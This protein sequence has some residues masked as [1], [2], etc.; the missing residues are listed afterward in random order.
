[1]ASVVAEASRS[2]RASII[3]SAAARHQ[4]GDRHVEVE[5][6]LL[7]DQLIDARGRRFV[8][9]EPANAEQVPKPA[10]AG[11]STDD[12]ARAYRAQRSDWVRSCFRPAE[13]SR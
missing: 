4:V 5:A 7:V 3:G 11:R 12:T 6:Q 2:L 8:M 9:E 10:H 13:V 1:M